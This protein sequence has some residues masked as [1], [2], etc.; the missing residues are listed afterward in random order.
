MADSMLAEIRRQRVG[1]LRALIAAYRLEHDF[2][3]DGAPSATCEMLAECSALADWLE[4]TT[5][6]TAVLE[7]PPVFDDDEMPF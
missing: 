6:P 3:R 4:A 5:P 7:A 2:M 1:W